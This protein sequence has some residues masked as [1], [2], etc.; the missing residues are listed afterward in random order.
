MRISIWIAGILALVALVA[1]VGVGQMILQPRLPLITDASFAPET[2]T[3]NADGESDVTILSYTLSRNANISLIF[4]QSD[5]TLYYFRKD[6]A[7]IADTYQVLFSGVVE[8]YTLTGENIAGTIERRLMPDGDY[9]WRLEAHN[10]ETGEVDERSGSLVI[11]GGK[12]VL[13]E[14]ISFTISPTTF[15]PNQD[16]IDDRVLISVFLAQPVEDL[17][18]YLLAPDGQQI[19]VPEVDG[20]REAG[21]A[22][23]HDF[24]YDGGIQQGS[25]PP[26]DGVYTVLVTAQDA[27]GQRISRSA[28]LVI[29]SGG[30]PQ[31]EIS[32]QPT[33]VDVVFT[34]M[35]YED[36]YFTDAKQ[37]GDLAAIPDNLS[38]LGFRAITIPQGDLLAFR[39]TVDN[40]GRVPIR[41]S[42]PWPGTVYQWDQVWGAMGVY[43]QSGAW[44]VGINCSTTSLP[45]PWRWAIG[46]PDQ[47]EQVVDEASGNTYY[48]LPPGQKSEVWGAVRMTELVRARNPQQCW[49]GLIH[50]DVEVTARN[51]RVGARDVTLIEAASN[52]QGD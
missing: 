23:R 16:G 1:V 14:I 26:V 32:Q 3:P 6:E 42:G 19:F 10:P 15:S 33:G 12:A 39:L 4:E 37:T 9:G 29:E 5:G 18:V 31:A 36:R 50:E 35:P 49:A 21:E 45:W 44:R 25:E 27:E 41:T 17:T 13:P 24:D 48:Y 51:S 43:E 30:K 52:E 22:G 11:S 28:S 7:R 40:Y 2:I 38:D 8:G 34:V 20:G 46:T 47:L